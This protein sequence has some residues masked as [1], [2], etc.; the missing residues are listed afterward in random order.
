MKKLYL[1]LVL[2]LSL[3]GANTAHALDLPTGILA[4]GEQVTTLETGKWYFLYNRGA[5]TY[6]KEASDGALVQAEAPNGINVTGNEG[7]L[8]TLEEANDG[9]YYIKTGLGNYFNNPIYNPR[10]TGTSPIAL[11]IE[12]ISGNNGHFLIKGTTGYNLV[13]PADGTPLRGR[14]ETAVNGIADWAF[15]KVEFTDVSQLKGEAL[16]NYQIANLKF[17]RLRNKRSSTMYLTS[18]TAGKATGEALAS[19]GLTQVWIAERSEAGFTVRNAHTGQYLQ[20]DFAKPANGAN[21]L[22]FQFSPNNTGDEAYCNISSES[23][24]S[25]Q[26]C[27]NLSNWNNSIAKWSYQNDAGSDW[28]IE[29]AEDVT[30]DDVRSHLNSERGYASELISGKYYRIL[31]TNY[32]MYATETD[33]AIRS[34]NKN[35]ANYAQY[36]KIV[37]NG[38]GYTIQNVLTQKYI[39]PQTTT[40]WE[41]ETA[42]SSATLYPARTSDK[43]LYMWTIAN[44]SGG[45]NGMH[46]NSGKSVVMW[47]IYADASIWAFQ[48]VELTDA[49]IEAA[50][51]ERAAYEELVKNIATYQAHLDN[52]FQ[53]KACTTLKDDIQALS[54]EQLAANEHYAALN[55]D[56]KA[57]VL[58]VKNDTW[59]QFT[60]KTTGY[61]AGYEKFF[62][63]A[64]YKIYSNHQDM[65]TKNEN[66]RMSNYFGRLSNPTGI[67]ANPGDI[68]Y[69]FVDEN[70]K[71]ECTLALEVVS[72]DGVSGN[73]STGTQITL[74]RG[75]NV[76][77]ASQQMLLYIF[78]QLNNTQ[79]YL[80]N[81]PDIKIH[82]EGGQLNGYW[83]ATRGMTNADWK[84]L[85]QDL[86]KAPFINM[87]T[88]HLVFQMDTPLVLAAE[89]NEI[90]GVMRIWEAIPTNEDRYM[91]VEDFEGRYNNIWNVFSGASSYM[92]SS[93]YGTWYSEGTI[94]AIMNYNNMRQPG[95]LWGPS[96]EIGHNHQA[97]INVCG[98]TESSNNLF[99]NINTFEQGIQ[100]SRCFLPSDNFAAWGN[101]IPWVG[102]DI[103][104]TTRMF[105]QLYLYFHAMHHDD[106]FL[107]NLFRMMR[108]KPFSKNDGWDSSTTYTYTE[109]GETK[110]GTGANI[111]LGKNDYLHLA[112]MICDVAQA[113]LS[114]FFETFGMF[115]P[116]KNFFVGDYANYLVTTTQADIDE[117]KAYM[118][119]YPKKLGNIMFIDDHILPMK[120][121][122]LDNPFEPLS[123]SNGKRNNNTSQ[124]DSSL[125]IGNFGDYEEYDGRTTFSTNNDYFKLN[126]KTISF[127][128]TGCLG[129]KIY[130][131]KG[132]LIWAT[133]AKT[134]TV[135]QRVADMGAENIVVVAV[136][137][138]MNDVPC[139]YYNSS[140]SK[141]YKTT[142]Y[143]GEEDNS[144]VWYS[145][146]S[147]GL[148]N[149]LP[150]NAIGVIGTKDAPEAIT[151]TANI[152]NT[153]GTATSIVL[154]GDK[155]AYIPVET[156]AANVMFTKSIEGYA[157][158]DLPFDV[159]STDVPGLQTA[160]V[161]GG[162]LTITNAESVA[163]GQPAVVNG[164]INLT[165]TNAIVKSGSY[166]V[167][168]IIALNNEAKATVNVEQA[169]PFTYAF[170]EL[171]TGIEAVCHDD[172]STNEKAMYDLSGRRVA[173]T[174]KAG[175][176]IVNGKKQ[177]VK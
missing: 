109:N 138:N 136:E 6:A 89:P 157:A 171:A 55:D 17:F 20:D 24:F 158:L 168:D 59:Q 50:R 45:G 84:L 105:F 80:A 67:V 102:R 46:T 74:K 92:H 47:S 63:I 132:N 21:V 94:N 108:K 56:L 16:Y 170:S 19:T 172:I 68:L 131:K 146:A 1:L 143:F 35:D 81:Y 77:Y 137:P 160:A 125:P 27:I 64:D 149:Y 147:T 23:D 7:Y 8:V 42:T 54:D 83:D 71:S 101:D 133:N 37:K 11:T 161:A 104:N 49:D 154:N 114:E 51:S 12:G 111:T 106:E 87:K 57:T 110:T 140:N 4:T 79:R 163:A 31:N 144:R 165:L 3:T 113:D 123:T 5:S 103:W 44:T 124:H 107:P 70:P 28:A 26:T 151:G 53:D 15:V 129:H 139:P 13:A 117:A 159:T 119:K 164:D 150:E 36:W 72:T 145:N 130:D 120:S 40:S 152:I 134:A 121:V 148:E 118:R 169:S 116:V 176:Y 99:S 2:L 177:V 60:N 62:R 141:I 126:G 115:V 30:E 90:E 66:F 135:P 82:I 96:H 95:S 9:K 52:L 175:I 86:L 32:G 39:Q 10:G 14:K 25:D 97:S 33:G 127:T 156:T 91:G 174:D 122:N 173:K 112:K 38:T 162:N 22:F 43:W 48:E 73:H 153:D 34:I 167:G 76:Y 128:G 142:V 98:T 58:K 93:T 18:A 166:Q 41:Y 61:T 75:L 78:H 65:A 29:M 69:I 85:Q 100:T 88:K 155:P